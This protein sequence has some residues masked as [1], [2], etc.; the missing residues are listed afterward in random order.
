[1]TAVTGTGLIWLLA[2]ALAGAE[3]EPE[4]VKE[5]LRQAL[6]HDE[7][8][9]QRLLNLYKGRIFS[10]VFR[11]VRHYH[12]AEEITFEVFIRAFRSLGA[13][14][15]KRPFSAWLFTIAHNLVIDHIRKSKP[16]VEL[17]DETHPA[18]DDLAA[19]YRF[20]RKI[21]QIE[22]ALQRLPTTDR[23]IVILFHKEDMSYEEIAKTLELPLS[24]VKIRLHRARI[25]LAEMVK[26]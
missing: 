2:L 19:R 21:E 15:L 12:D 8:A 26:K 17:L 5:L 11:L 4:Q 9:C 24:T 16:A 13:F 25:K 10:Y 18:P 14:D 1:M 7:N 22:A 3:A 6:A 20:K 23:E